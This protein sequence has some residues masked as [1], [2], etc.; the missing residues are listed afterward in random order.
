MNTDGTDF[1]AYKECHQT[2][3]LWNHITTDHREEEQLEDQRNVGESSCNSGDGTDQRVKPL[4]F[5]IRFQDNQHMKVL[6]LSAV[7]TD[8]LYP[9]EIFLVLISVRGGANPRA[10]VR[11][12]VLCQ[13]KIPGTPS[14]IEPATLLLVAKCLNQL[15][16]QQ[17]APISM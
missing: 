14:G 16:H 13:W 17:R 12:E 15:R 5:M 1:Y 10:I 11:P 2:E 9:Q 8:R 6:R 3:S 7:H 4:V